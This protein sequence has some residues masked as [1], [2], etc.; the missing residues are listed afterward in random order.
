[1]PWP[2]SVKRLKFT[3]P[4][5]TF[6]QNLPHEQRLPNPRK[7]A[8]ISQFR[9][10]KYKTHRL[11][12]HCPRQN[13]KI[14]KKPIY[15]FLA[16]LLKSVPPADL[17][18]ELFDQQSRK[19]WLCIERCAAKNTTRGRCVEDV[20]VRAAGWPWRGYCPK[21]SRFGGPCGCFTRLHLCRGGIDE[22]HPK[23]PPPNMRRRRG[24]ESVQSCAHRVPGACF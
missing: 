19:Q 20:R 14:E 7:S 11:D 6:F 10:P 22:L 2:V 23:L 17:Q 9:T 4:P 16:I 21:L 13:R 24:G 8:E 12:R 1:M 5:S 18:V 3:P 15:I